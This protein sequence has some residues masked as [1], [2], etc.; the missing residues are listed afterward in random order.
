M[1]SLIILLV[2]T[3][4]ALALAFGLARI[5]IRLQQPP[6]IAALAGVMICWQMIALVAGRTPLASSMMLLIIGV[7]LITL[8]QW[9]RANQRLQG[10]TG[11]GGYALAVFLPALAAMFP[12]LTATEALAFAL[13][14]GLTLFGVFMAVARA[15]SPAPIG[16]L[17]IPSMLLLGLWLVVR[18]ISAFP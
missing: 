15:R 6:G 9:L 14:F 10:A 12:D 4:L 17:G 13:T 1:S 5:A 7:S 8:I 16:W 11:W 2:S 18:L 3:P